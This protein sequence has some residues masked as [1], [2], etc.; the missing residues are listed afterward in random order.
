MENK[1]L[2]KVDLIFEKID[3][4]EVLTKAYK[5]S[6]DEIIQRCAGIRAERTRRCRFPD[7]VEMEIYCCRKR[8]PRSILSAT[9]M[10]ENQEHS[11]T[12]RSST[13]LHIKYTEAW[14]LPVKQSAQKKELYICVENTGFFCHNLMLELESFHKMIKDIGFDF[15][16]NYC[17]GKR[18]IYLR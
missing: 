4:K 13:G 14:Q 12:G 16:I 17:L 9:L 7:R 18:S 10:K 1:G 6:N 5:M 15:K 3:P 2:N 11:R 8:T